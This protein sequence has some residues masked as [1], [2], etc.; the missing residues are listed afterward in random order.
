MVQVLQPHRNSID[1]GSMR[2][3]HVVH[4]SVSYVLFMLLLLWRPPHNL[5][6]VRIFLSTISSVFVA[7]FMLE[8]SFHIVPVQFHALESSKALWCMA[9]GMGSTHPHNWVAT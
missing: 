2:P 9:F 3:K 7:F 4:V 1:E 6:V 5:F 8:D